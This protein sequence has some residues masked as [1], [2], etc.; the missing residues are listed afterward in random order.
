MGTAGVRPQQPTQSPVVRPH[1]PTQPAVVRPQ[2]PTQPA[3]VR[4]QQPPQPAVVRQHQ[5]TQPTVVRVIILLEPIAREGGF[6]RGGCHFSYRLAMLF[7]PRRVAFLQYLKPPFH[8]VWKYINMYRFYIES[9]NTRTNGN[10]SSI[11]MDER[12]PF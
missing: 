1:Q 3:G 4:P 10:G 11:L 7:L 9:C 8:L 5:P 2:Q 6:G 12:Y